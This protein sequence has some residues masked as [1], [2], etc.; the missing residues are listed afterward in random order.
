MEG[1]TTVLPAGPEVAPK[2]RKKSQAEDL[3][4]AYFVE[5]F[6]GTGVLT[7]AV[8]RLG[9]ACAE[10]EDVVTGGTDFRVHGQVEQLKE[11][12]SEMAERTRHLFIHLA[13]PCATF[14]R[15]RDR[16]VR[17]RL[18]NNWYPGGLPGKEAQ[19]KEANQVA[20]RA[21][22]L[23]CWAAV[24][25]GAK[26]TLE[27][28]R[29]SYLWQFV[30]KFTPAEADFYDLHFSP[31]LHGSEFQKPTTLRC[32]NWKPTKLEG[33]CTLRENVFTCGRTREEGH[34]VLEFGGAKT[35][36]AA[37][38]A[39]GVCKKWAYAIGEEA[40]TDVDHKISLDEVDLTDIKGQEAQVQR[41]RPTLR[42][43]VAGCG[44]RELQGWQA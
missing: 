29:R 36:E 12:L 23:A 8:R 14:S 6:A 34:T 41:S 35:H 16:S 28:P 2:K 21:Y 5:L 15:A 22:K 27:N 17:T 4:Q 26:V 7:K 42:E 18:R 33:V 3:T 32:W 24:E 19:T 31:C 11:Q 44:R 38:Y 30:D 37:E 10:P 9:I 20:R 43:G 39:E 1:A 13:P 40:A 25:L